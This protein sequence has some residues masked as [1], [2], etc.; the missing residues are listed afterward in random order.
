DI[1]QAVKIPVIGCGGVQSGRDAIEMMMAG[2]RAVQVGT[3][4]YYRGKDVF[5]LICQEIKEFTQEEN[6]ESLDEIIGIIH[7]NYQARNYVI[8]HS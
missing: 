4:I 6:I 2:A 1:F 7:Q 3:G 5:K 8:R